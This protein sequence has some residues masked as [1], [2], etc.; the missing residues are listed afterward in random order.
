M[1]TSGYAAPCVTTVDGREVL[2]SCAVGELSQGRKRI[3]ILDV[4]PADAE[5]LKLSQSL[6]LSVEGLGKLSIIVTQ[7]CGPRATFAVVER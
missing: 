6:M 3:G 2:G 4:G 1:I 5:H 7:L